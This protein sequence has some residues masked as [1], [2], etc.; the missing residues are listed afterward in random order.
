[1]KITQ[2]GLE[3]DYPAFLKRKIIISNM[4]G[5]IIAFL[6]ALPFV[7]ISLLFFPPL[8]HLPI[9]AIPIALSTLLLNFLRFH[10]LARIVISLVPVCLAAVYQAYLST[11]GEPVNPGLAMIILSFSMVIFVIFDLREKNKI[12]FM[13]LVMLTIMLSMDQLN[14]AL[15]MELETEVIETGFLAKMVAVISL[16]SSVGCILILVFQN[17]ES[18]KETFSYCVKARSI[19]DGWRKR[20][21]S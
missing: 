10:N 20:N 11:G 7:F 4:I 19:R 5:L 21:W 12:I 17:S 14:M 2:L 9:I 13:S 16:I 1:M 3:D 8:A 15:E 18:E 6:V